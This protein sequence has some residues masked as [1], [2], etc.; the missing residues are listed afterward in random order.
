MSTDNHGLVELGTRALEPDTLEV[1]LEVPET[2]PLF[3]DHFGPLPVLPAFLI[4]DVSRDLSKRQWPSLG[5][6][7]SMPRLKLL[8]PISPGECPVV[9]LQRSAQ[10]VRFWWRVEKDGAPVDVVV[11]QIRFTEEAGP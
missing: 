2:L 1:R 7:T 10:E 6:W 5:T 3:R 11:G 4:V 9:E 8:A